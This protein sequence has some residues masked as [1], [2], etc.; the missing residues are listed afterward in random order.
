M[1]LQDYKSDFPPPPRGLQTVGMLLILATL[2]MLFA[3]C[4]L[5]YVF[6]RIYS[7]HPAA[8]RSLRL[9][10]L[11]WVSTAM[12]IGVSICFRGAVKSV[13]RER[14]VMVR[15]WLG[16][17][18]LCAV[19]FLAI[20]TPALIELLQKH[21]VLRSQNVTIYGLIFVLV[22]LHAA[23]VVGGMIGLGVVVHH[24]CKGM[25]DHEHY[26]G[27]SNAAMY[28]HFLDAVWLVMFGIFWF[29]G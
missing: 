23:H 4:M 29:L 11:L 3:S 15:R 28:W 2:F 6:I 8:A 9:P 21:F 12:M 5:A 22:L 19:A 18:A 10:Q 1:P 25:Y 17:A 16:L 14:Q 13:R 27:L 24:A 26:Y 20:Q 7:P